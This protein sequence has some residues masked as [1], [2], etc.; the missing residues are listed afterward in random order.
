MYPPISPVAPTLDVD[1]VVK[2]PL[3]AVVLPMEPG[4]AHVS[5]NNVEEFTEPVPENVSAPPDPTVSVPAA[6]VP[7]VRP[8]K[9]NPVPLVRVIELGVP[10]L[11]VVITQFTVMQRLPVPLWL[12]VESAVPPLIDRLVLARSVVNA[13]VEG[14]VLPIA[15]GAD[16]VFPSSVDALIT[17]PSAKSS[18]PPEPM[19][20]VFVNVTAPEKATVP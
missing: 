1:R 3:P 12:L 2:F 5:P 11:G 17:P 15:P 19:V 7:V 13:P 6:S 10:R 9:G 14:V 20:T 18:S 4:A 8:L 16:H